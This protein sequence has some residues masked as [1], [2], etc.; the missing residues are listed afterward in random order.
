MG[1]PNRRH[2][3]PR[4]AGAV[5][6]T[7]LAGMLLGT[8]S[9]AL[10]YVRYRTSPPVTGG[11]GAPYAWG[12]SSISILGY[13][14][15]IPT[16]PVDQIG[17][18]MTAAV[19]AWSKE[20]PD[21]GACSFLDLAVAIQPVDSIPP[22]AVHDN[23]NTIA[24]RDGVWTSIC[25]MTKDGGMDCHQ[26]GELA[27]T[28]VWSRGCGEIVEADVE[29]NA[30]Q[31]AASP[32]AWADLDVTPANGVYHDLQNAL[33][34]EMGHF[35]GLDHTCALPGANVAGEVDNLGNPVPDCADAT[36]AE[37]DATMYPS[38]QPGD[39]SKRTLSPDDRDGLCAIYPVG[40]VPVMCGGGGASSGGCSVAADAGPAGPTTAKWFTLLGG[41]V[42]MLALIASRRRR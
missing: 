42:G 7:S 37:M 29:V 27:L 13:P 26:P 21:N 11:L 40:T 4:R 38:A 9:P 5:L 2:P 30:D 12:R 3:A 31:S 1:A 23:I 10:A 15:G 36:L 18:A 22:A 17:A 24:L 6:A 34:H 41:A 33:T 32:F 16:M 25:T 20:D 8:A 19:A 39:L 14:H 35:I 28:T